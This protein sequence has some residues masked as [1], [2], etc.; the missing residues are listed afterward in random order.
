M[1]GFIPKLKNVKVQVNSMV[2]TAQSVSR[3]ME[4]LKAE[5]EKLSNYSNIMDL[6]D[7][8]M[9]D[10]HGIMI[11]QGSGAGTPRY[12]KVSDE[13][14]ITNQLFFIGI[15]P[16]GTCSTCEEV[17]VTDDTIS[18]NVCRNYFHATNCLDEHKTKKLATTTLLKCLRTA[19]KNF[20]WMCNVCST[21]YEQ[22]GC[23]NVQSTA[24]TLTE[25]VNKLTSQM[26]NLKLD[27]DTRFDKITDKIM[28]SDS[29]N[30]WSDK[31]RLSNIR[32]SLLIKPGGAG[33]PVELDMIRKLAVKMEF[34]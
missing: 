18:C 16:T 15:R 11:G 31:N 28:E 8:H 26:D 27:M 32:S 12:G 25:T 6:I 34:R 20:K 19:S 3:D 17:P 7:G 24:I 13:S 10:W 33:K 23:S 30:V 2:T 22:A 29:G 4:K 21:H 14:A 5:N 1:Y 9:T